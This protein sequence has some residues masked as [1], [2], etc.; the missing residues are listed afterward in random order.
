MA[1]HVLRALVCLFPKQEVSGMKL[2]SVIVVVCVV[3][4]SSP[5]FGTIYDN[6][7][8]DDGPLQTAA[9]IES[10]SSVKASVKGGDDV[11]EIGKRTGNTPLHWAVNSGRVSL[12][13]FSP[14]AGLPNFPK[15]DKKKLLEYI[16]IVRFLVRNGADVNIKDKYGGTVLHQVASQGK[17]AMAEI[18]IR[19]GRA[20]VN[21]KN[22]HQDSPLHVARN[23]MIVSLLNS[24]G[25][26]VHARNNFGSTPLHL[27]RDAEITRLLIDAGAK[28]TVR[29]KDG[30]TPL[31][32]GIYGSPSVITLL[33]KAGAEVDAWDK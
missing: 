7:Y 27:A 13:S 25:G 11:N 3:L 14:A 15:P 12:V 10:L 20:D 5:A 19:E 4:F 22:R 2:Q 17:T 28:A 26:D 16:E 29:N 31:H 8:L 23:P 30:A 1:R 33:V 21:L 32:M 6:S 9:Y 18:I 24:S